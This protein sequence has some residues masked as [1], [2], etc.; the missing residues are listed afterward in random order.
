M[1]VSSVAMFV[2]LRLLPLDFFRI[3]NEPIQLL[4]L[5]ASYLACAVPF[6][7]AGLVTAIAFA[8]GTHR[9][10]A[11]YA[12]AMGGSA[13]GGVAAAGAAAAGRGCAP[14]WSF[15][16]WCCCRWRCCRYRAP[17]PAAAERGAGAGCCPVLALP[18]AVLGAAMVLGHPALE[19]RPGPYKYL[20]HVLRFPD[21]RQVTRHDTIRG[22]IDEVAGPTIRFAPGLSLGAG[23]VVPAQRALVRDGDAALFVAEDTAEAEGGTGA[24]LRGDPSGRGVP[25]R[26]GAAHGAGAAG[27]RRGAAGGC[28]VDGQPGTGRGT[29][30]RHRPPPPGPARAGDPPRCR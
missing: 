27:R 12:A 5:A 8:A 17:R 16:R 11:V 26:A 25:P 6:F 18:A 15:R 24:W 29:E 9:P 28:A 10:G 22:R 1:A 30:Q 4:F 13:A 20:A 19:P 2:V 23:I 7:F 21:T 14:R 3:P